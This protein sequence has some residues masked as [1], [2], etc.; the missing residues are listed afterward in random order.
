MRALLAVSS[1]ALAASLALGFAHAQTAAPAP[2][3]KAVVAT[4]NGETITEAD[5]TLAL[6]DLASQVPNLPPDRQRQV[7][8]DFLIEVKVAAQAAKGE[9]FEDSDDF[10]RKMVYARERILMERLLNRAGEKAANEAAVRAF[11]DEQVKQL[12]PVEEVRA[13][14]I[15]VEG[16][17]DAKKIHARVKGGEDFAKV[18]AELSKDPG[19]GKEGGDLGFFT[20]EQM[21]KEFADAAFALKASEISAPVKSQFGWHVIKLE[22]RRNRPVP[23][24]ET[25]KDRL[26]QALGQKAQGDLIAELRKKAKIDMPT[27]PAEQKKP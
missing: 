24:Y 6:E 4:V 8:L 13:R 25:V 20:K 10:K 19:S 7:A 15:L 27:A 22:E 2:S 26:A 23:A 21:V 9:K 11:Y 18:A 1:F 5:V 12:K 14:H 16:E 3:G 17:E